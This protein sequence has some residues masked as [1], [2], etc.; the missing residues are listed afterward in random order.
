MGDV[1][2]V[3]VGLMKGTLAPF[4]MWSCHLQFIWPRV[5]FE[6][7]RILEIYCAFHVC[8]IVCDNVNL[9]FQALL[10]AIVALSVIA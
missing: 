9:H 7:V 10:M 2:S 8:W 6:Y 3:C 1:I 5:V 4:Y